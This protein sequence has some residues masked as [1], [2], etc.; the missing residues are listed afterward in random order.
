MPNRKRWWVAVALLL[1]PGLA[2][3]QNIAFRDVPVPEDVPA[4][5][6]TAFAEDRDGFLWIGT[7][8]GL[9]RYD[10]RRFRV[11]GASEDETS[12]GGNYVRGLLPTRD[13]RLWVSTFGG[14]LSVFDPL[15]EKFTR[16]RHDPAD[17]GSLASNRT[18]G[19]AEDGDGFVWVATGEGL[20]RIDPARG[21]IEHFRQDPARPDSLLDN[22]ARALLRRRDGSLWVGTRL[23]LQRYLGN[24]R[25]EQIAADSLAGVFVSR[26]FEDSAGR[27]FIGTTE[28]GVAMLDPA[29][30]LRRIPPR[31]ASPEGLSH[32]W[33]YGF[34]EISPQ[35]IWIATFGGGVDV[36]D[37]QNLVVKKRLRA[38]PTLPDAVGGDRI[39]ALFKD[40]SGLVWL[41]TW[42][43]GLQVHDPAARAF[44]A[45]RSSPHLPEG[46]SHPAAV[47]AIER[48][49][50]EL[51]VGTNG[52]GIDV[53]SQDLRLLRGY[54][55]APDDPGALA[56]G[57]ITCLAEGP[58]GSLWV[59]T[60]DG[61]LQVLPP[62]GQ[63]FRR[64]GKKDGLPGGQ[65][66]ALTF[67]ADGILWAGSSEG[68][69]RIDPASFEIR[70]FRH[71]PEDS[72][73]IGGH[74]VE[75]VAF[76]AEG[77]L[78]LG[79]DAGLDLF[80]P[81]TGKS[82]HFRHQPGNKNSLPNDWVP[83][84][85]LASDG[86]LWVATH[87]G[88]AL[89]RWPA[90]ASG[91]DAEPTFESLADRLRPHLGPVDS[92]IEDAE[93]QIW[94]GPRLRVDPKTFRYSTFGPA[95]G[96]SLRSF[97]I[98]SR[99]RRQD[100]SLLFGSPEG[101]LIVDPARLESWT[102][103]P[104]VVASALRID[105]RELPGASRRRELVLRP[106]QRSFSV[107]FS[108][109]DF[110]APERNRYRIQLAGY[111][112][113]WQEMDASFPSVTYGNLDPGSYRLQVQ[114]SNRAGLFSPRALE[115]AVEVEPAF[116]QT[117][118]F[119]LLAV[120]FLALGLFGL[121]QLRQYQLER[122]SLALEMVVRERTAELE[123]AYEKI[124]EASLT[125]PL[126]GLRNRRFLE[127]TLNADVELTRRRR[128][129]GSDDADLVF[130]LLDL[131]HF[132]S[133]NDTWGHAAGDA[134]LIE[135]AHRLKAH[136]RSSDH[137]VRWGG[138][139]FLA[140]AR[141]LP[142]QEAATLAEKLRLAIGE[143]NFVLPTGERITKTVSVGYVAF[144]IDGQEIDEIGWE[145]AIDFADQALYDAKSQGRNRCIA[146]EK[147]A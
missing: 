109:L 137:L 110:T 143:K 36:I 55:P 68:L 88:V 123:R 31:P 133:V 120:A 83:D 119:R 112:T 142:R 77:R 15:T 121:I 92:L 131:D 64:L 42:G 93:G 38:D 86:T 48:R 105:G 84:L 21:T 6:I 27:L 30:Q 12:L 113:R 139:E 72:D 125:D 57:A 80:D 7:Q 91:A 134:V 9:L 129:D 47:R 117:T 97:F 107:D 85:L 106:D 34:A 3:A 135:A 98:A 102:Y 63:R 51:W 14:G 116:H 145:K 25:F 50:G 5:V 141:F 82:R 11:F 87:G 138:E 118:L 2:G 124:K 56:D 73:S 81:I 33:V 18:E 122:R 74:A 29:G 45:L 58:D 78:F 70:A 95:D 140:V 16:F 40:A 10:G 89:L 37:P 71:R 32:F 8:S 35:E 69:A 61:T 62:G 43:Q 75:A 44:R 24:G 111:E 65:I 127:Q 104:P 41:G 146:Y 4:H 147:R 132:K 59:A 13:G 23:G 126:T 60:L 17:A 96:C 101:L 28:H 1:A 26:L 114:G 20:D 49:S 90:G 79:T 128:Q 108:A 54:R 103:Q 136:L 22:R 67:G 94:L 46:L 115:I 19:L 66:R 52:N 39:G 144:P 76:D 130:L 99:F 100:G 53:F